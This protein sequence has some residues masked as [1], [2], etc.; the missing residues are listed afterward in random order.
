MCCF[1]DSPGQLILNVKDNSNKLVLTS[2]DKKTGKTYS[3]VDFIC[4]KSGIYQ[5]S[6]DFADEK[7]GSGV[8]VISLV[9]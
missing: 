4:N 3:I 7:R 1:D 5:V 2:Y 8:S 9:K 6:F